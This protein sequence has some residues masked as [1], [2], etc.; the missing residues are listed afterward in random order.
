MHK[1][2]K[3]LD[4]STGRIFISR[5]VVFDEA[6]FPFS[7]PGVSV[8]VSTL[9]QAI[10]FPSDEPAT[11]EPMRNYDLFYLTANPPG[12]GTV[13]LSQVPDVVADATP[14]RSLHDNNP[15]HCVVDVHEGSMHST[16]MHNMSPEA[17]SPEEACS[18]A[19]SSSAS[20][21]SSGSAPLGTACP[22]QVFPAAILHLELEQPSS[23][24]PSVASP[25][26]DPVP[27]HPM[28]TR[29]RDHTR[30]DK[31]YTDGTVRYDSRR[32]AFFAAPIS[33]HDA[34]REPEW[35]A[36]MSA[37][38]D[39]LSQT[40]TWTLVPRPPGVNIVG[41]K[42]IFKTKH[43]PD[44]SIDKHKARLVARGF[45]QQHGIDY[46]DTFSPV[47]KPETVRLVLSLAVSRG[48]TLRQVYVSNAFL[49][50][51]LS[52]N[53]YMQQPP[54]FEDSHY[55]S[56]VCKLQRSIYGLK[57]SP[58]AWYARL[59][60][61]LFQ[62]GFVSSKA[63]TSLFIF[64]QGD[65]RIYMLVYVDDIVIAG[66]T[67]AVVDR[68]VQS[69]SES[70]PIKDMGK[71]DYFLGLEAAY[72]SGGMT[73]TQRKYA[74]DLLH[75]VS[76][77]NC[78]PTSTPLRATEQLARDTGTLLGADDSLRYRSV[79]G[80]LQYLTL[81]RP[82]I[83]FAETK[84]VSFSLSLLMSIGKL[85]SEY[86]DMLKELCRQAC[87]FVSPLLQE[88]VF[89]P[90]LIGLDAWMTVDPQ[91]VLLFLLD[92]ILSHGVQ[93]NSPQSRDLVPRLSIRHWLMALL[94]LFG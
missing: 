41:S 81:T 6:V 86:C 75:R 5:D 54:G 36:A 18:S 30:K 65:I 94:K 66:S 77:E 63:D 70:F 50:G 21:M 48:W 67:T 28:V 22:S 62:L 8:N 9:E 71:L 93:R 84:C 69:L 58:R 61:C 27:T 29:H 45:T 1:G 11:S 35:Y 91:E 23:P 52:E 83:S 44:G 87:K 76:M 60:E 68:L 2:Y 32:R 85:S 15:G 80:G 33:H 4:R 17:A 47:V 3:C 14:V 72:T 34:L 19:D 64:S 43:R 56:H 53:V 82:D 88:L 78:N 10:T 57:Q 39:A 49:H 31:A 42:W 89:S 25:V 12:L 16:S 7:T 20:V 51:F 92:Q 55:P 37:E 46:G 90:M 38:F 74:L 79:V 40:K 24:T 59:S 26:D 13:F 73:L